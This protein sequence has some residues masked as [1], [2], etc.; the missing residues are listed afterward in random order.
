M[1]YIIKTL[2][3]PQSRP[4][5][6]RH[7]TSVRTYEKS[8][9]KAY[10]RNVQLQLMISKPKLIDKGPIYVN[11]VFYVYPPKTVVSSK[12]KRSKVEQELVYC[13]KKPDLDNYFKA[14]TDAA[15]GILYKNDGQ[16]AAISTQKLY[17]FKPRVE[18]EI[19]FLNERGEL[20]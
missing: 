4:R 12:T 17:S 20:T 7:G 8:D 6:S 19:D 5:F 1:K 18:L 10:K 9:M 15:E 3:K 14:I 16:I 11:I 13:D 2:P